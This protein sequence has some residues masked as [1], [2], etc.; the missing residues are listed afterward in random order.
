M[1]AHGRQHTITFPFQYI[2]RCCHLENQ[3]E[4]PARYGCE[5]VP[6]SLLEPM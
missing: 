1:I 2:G 3:D 4:L 6:L 5:E